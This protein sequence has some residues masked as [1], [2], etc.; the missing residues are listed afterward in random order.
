MMSLSPTAPIKLLSTEGASLRLTSGIKEL[1]STTPSLP[2][3]GAPILTAVA[4]ATV[5]YTAGGFLIHYL[6]KYKP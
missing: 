5:G 2:E 4:L 1:T 6:R 3:D